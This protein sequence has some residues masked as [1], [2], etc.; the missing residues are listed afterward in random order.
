[1]S[2]IRAEFEEWVRDRLKNSGKGFIEVSLDRYELPVD[3]YKIFWVSIAWESWQ[4]SR[5]R[6]KGEPVAI[7]DRV[8]IMQ[9]LSPYTNLPEG[10]KLYT[11]HASGET[12]IPVTTSPSNLLQDAQD[13]RESIDDTTTRGNFNVD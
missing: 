3:N 9:R 8:G 10:T 11:H 1:M 12:G 5:N 2:D 7:V 4:A 13:Y 6:L